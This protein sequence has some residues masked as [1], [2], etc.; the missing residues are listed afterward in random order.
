MRR[1]APDARQRAQGFAQRQQ[2]AGCRETLADASSDSLQVGQATK[3]DLQPAARE[4]ILQEHADPIQSLLE[5]LA[6]T[7]R[8][9]EP[10]SQLAR[11]HRGGSLPN[12]QAGQVVRARQ[13]VS[14]ESKA[15]AGRWIKVHECLG[16]LRMQPQH[17]GAELQVRALRVAQKGMPG[18]E[19][20]RPLIAAKRGERL[21]PKHR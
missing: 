9:I 3:L 16:M 21:D 18:G 17:P 2:V 15:A 1:D 7:Q 11:A 13:P 10:A 6:V 20:F 12:D 14:G 8:L 19:R 4:R 5:S